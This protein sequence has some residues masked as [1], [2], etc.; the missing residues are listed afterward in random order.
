LSRNPFQNFFQASV[1]LEFK[2][3]LYNY[4]RRRDEIR[5]LLNPEEGI[6]LEIGSGVSP[7]CE[8]QANT[9][10]SDISLEAMHYM[11]EHHRADQAVVMSALR[12]PFQDESVSTIVCSEV[13]EHIPRYGKAL[14]EMA[15]VL[16]TGGRLILTLPLH[17]YYFSIDDHFVGHL[18]R[19]EINSLLTELKE[20]GFEDF[21]LSKITG[22]LEKMTMIFIVGLFSLLSI[23]PKGKSGGQKSPEA[24]KIV[25]PLYQFLNRLYAH[26]V[27]WE[28]KCTPW[29]VTSVALVACR[30]KTR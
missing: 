24:F 1:Y 30:K 3:H 6:I 21:Y 28:A 10:Y 7:I 18:R 4:R 15:R 14:A 16:K 19:Y 23:F 13:I 17:M 9:I 12:I 22:F 25:L 27:K 2:N 11:K 29:A 20:L 8:A 26:L 5:K